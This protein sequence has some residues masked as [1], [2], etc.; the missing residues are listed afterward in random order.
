MD[1]RKKYSNMFYVLH[2]VRIK[3][4]INIYLKKKL[5]KT[6]ELRINCRRDVHPKI[7]SSCTYKL[8]Y[9]I[10]NFI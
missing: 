1:T 9:F 5:K 6:G 7:L 4:E 10:F 2:I 8:T 3:V